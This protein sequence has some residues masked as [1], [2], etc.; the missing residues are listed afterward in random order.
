MVFGITEATE[1]AFY[2]GNKSWNRNIGA[3]R[4]FLFHT[5][6]LELYFPDDCERLEKFIENNTKGNILIKSKIHKFAT[7]PGK[8]LIKIRTQ[9][10][11]DALIIK[12]GW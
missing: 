12:L 7:A 3:S 8:K 9:R 6:T 10:K 11:E 2:W 1:R 5:V 4:L